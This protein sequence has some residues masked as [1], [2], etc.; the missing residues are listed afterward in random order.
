MHV[1]AGRALRRINDLLA[2][3][4]RVVVV[5]AVVVML[6]SLAAQV[7]MRY[8]FGMA[9]TWSEELTLLLF[10]WVVLLMSALGVREGF[11]VR[12][13]LIVGHLPPRAQ[14]SLARAIELAVLAA[15]SFLCWQGWRYF[16]ETRGTVSAAIAYPI[17]L[18]HLA[19]PVGGLLIAAFALERL[20]DPPPAV[21]QER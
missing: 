2:A 16:A 1:T 4:T 14:A 8:V 10:S 18:L 15:G 19:A 7:V 13:D 20:V 21:H 6:A 3:A 12:M 5:A 9:L 11:H 17:E